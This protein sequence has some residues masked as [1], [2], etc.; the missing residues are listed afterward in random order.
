MSS[1][2]SWRT[3]STKPATMRTTRTMRNLI[4]LRERVERL[5]VLVGEA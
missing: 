1:T 4:A 2:P 3:T 5:R